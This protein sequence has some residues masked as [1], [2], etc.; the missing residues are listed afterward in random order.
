TF[1]LVIG[2][3]WV[4]NVLARPITPARALL[5][6]SMVAAFGLILAIAGVRNWFA[7]EGPTTAVIWSSVIC[8]AVGAVILELGWQVVQWRK[9]VED[10]TK[11]LALRNAA[12]GAL[13]TSFDVSR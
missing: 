2:G 1:T 7:L 9:P 13:D 3:L 8:G 5:F 10:R 12:A 11:R 4:L 6:G